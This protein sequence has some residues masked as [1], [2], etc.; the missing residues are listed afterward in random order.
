M[1]LLFAALLPH[2]QQQVAS[3][4]KVR[5]FSNAKLTLEPADAT[6]WSDGTPHS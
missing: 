1:C 5:D 4:I 3:Q 2:V 6:S